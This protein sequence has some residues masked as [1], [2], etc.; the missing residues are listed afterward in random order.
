LEQGFVKWVTA[1][2]AVGLEIGSSSSSLSVTASIIAT[3][4]FPVSKVK[5]NYEVKIMSTAGLNKS[6]SYS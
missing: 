4:F 3:P 6:S 2:F 5:Y 1:F